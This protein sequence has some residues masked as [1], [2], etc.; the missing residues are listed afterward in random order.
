MRYEGTSNAEYG[1]SAETHSSKGIIAKCVTDFRG[2]VFEGGGTLVE[3]A[4]PIVYEP[5]VCGLLEIACD[6]LIVVQHVL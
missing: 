6:G 1:L 3:T 5:C 4:R 2:R